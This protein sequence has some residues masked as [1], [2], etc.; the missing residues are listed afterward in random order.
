MRL[1]ANDMVLVTKGK[2]RGKQARISRVL[3]KHHQVVV[4]GINVVT[5]HQ[6]PTG[7]FR[8][9]GIIQKEMPVPVANVMFFCE[10]CTSPSKIGFR[11]L[12]D[13]TKV[14]TCKKCSEV[15]E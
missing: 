11:Y 4:E 14:R 3:P 15:I 1:H 12:P 6:R 7:T 2:D 9:G 5:R 13:G 10:Q 8:Q